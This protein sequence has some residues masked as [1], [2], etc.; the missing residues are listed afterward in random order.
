MSFKMNLFKDTTIISEESY[1]PDYQVAEN[2]N[3]IPRWLSHTVILSETEEIHLE[4]N[5]YFF[6]ESIAYQCSNLLKTYIHSLIEQNQ[7]RN[8]VDFYD[9][10]RMIEEYAKNKYNNYLGCVSISYKNSPGQFNI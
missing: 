1:S 9:K 8:A 6:K 10:I 7:I 2:D 4:L 3:P 5:L